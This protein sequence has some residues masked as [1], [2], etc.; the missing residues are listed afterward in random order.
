MSGYG[1]KVPPE[2]EARMYAVMVATARQFFASDLVP[3]PA[4][5]QRM[6]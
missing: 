2:V 6:G 3:H 4:S 1:S 5:G